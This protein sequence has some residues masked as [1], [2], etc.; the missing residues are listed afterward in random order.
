[1]RQLSIKE[2]TEKRQLLASISL[3]KDEKNEKKN[4]AQDKLNYAIMKLNK[5]L[6]RAF[7]K[8]STD[9]NEK[10]EDIRIKHASVYPSD[11]PD[12]EKRGLLVLNEKGEYTYTKEATQEFNKEIRPLDA[13]FQDIMVD[14]EG[15]DYFADDNWARIEDV[16]LYTREEL[17]GWLFKPTELTIKTLKIHK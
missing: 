4:V 9:H 6:E 7:I 10:R 5:R 14:I 17:E 12:K 13:S 1:M 3:I 8:A 16:S 11:F 15:E 2:L